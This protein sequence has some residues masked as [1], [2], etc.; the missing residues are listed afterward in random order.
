MRRRSTEIIQYLIKNSDQNM[1]LKELALKYEISQK[2]LKSDMKEINQFLRTIPAQEIEISDNGQIVLG[3]DFKSFQIQQYLYEMDTY[4]YKFSPDE[5]QIY[6][7]MKLVIANSYITM[8]SLAEELSVSRITIV[9]D[10]EVI[11]EKFKNKDNILTLDSG[12]G[13]LLECNEKEKI[14]L[15]IELYR[16]IAVNVQND[17]FFQRMILNQVTIKYRF[18]QIFE[19]MQEFMQVSNMVFVEDVF[20][21][22]VLY[23]FVIFNFAKKEGG[24]VDRQ[25]K[26]SGIDHMI[27]YAGHMLDV[28]VTQEMVEDFQQ[29]ISDHEL[30]SFVKTVDEIELYKVIMRFIRAVDEETQLN[31]V[32]DGKLMDSLLMH[33]RSMK[34]WGN[35]EVEFPENTSIDYEWLEKIV[36]KNVYILEKFLTYKLS[37]NMRKSIVI[38]ICVAIIRNRKNMTKISVVIVCPGSMATGKYLEAQIKNYFDFHIIGVLAAHEV[39]QKLEKSEEQVDFIISTVSIRTE[40]YKVIKVHPFLQMEDMNLIQKETFQNQRM[41]PTTFQQNRNY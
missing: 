36:D 13:M 8:Q 22:I 11:K 18:S 7:M 17:G 1:T 21:D 6:I 27:L 5:R 2:V 23:L 15:L 24:G 29:Y 37:E 40:K 14:E 9:N 41:K 20:Y 32:N 26:L 12:K 16:A 4:M 30:R 10:M 39:I 3:E 31:L 35:Y 33:I 28:T 34:D 38:H 25:Q 19:Y